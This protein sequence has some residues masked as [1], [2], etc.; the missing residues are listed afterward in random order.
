M[1][2]DIGIMLRTRFF[3]DLRPYVI[4]VLFVF[5]FTNAFTKFMRRQ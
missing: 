5:Y 2:N 4:L 1:S 3:S